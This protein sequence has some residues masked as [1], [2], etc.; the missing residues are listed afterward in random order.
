MW[1]C[2]VVCACRQERHMT[3]LM[4][5]SQRL[6]PR[7]SK[8]ARLSMTIA[9]WLC[10]A[11]EKCLALPLSALGLKREQL[12]LCYRRLVNVKAEELT[13]VLLKLEYKCIYYS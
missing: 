13:S 3:Y 10:I 9:L 8:A 12:P 7:C 5:Q 1:L 2:I 6:L 11:L 4:I